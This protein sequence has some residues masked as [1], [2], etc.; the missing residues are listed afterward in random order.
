MNEETLPPSPNWYLSNVLA[1]RADGT[2]AYGSRNSIVI[3]KYLP[4]KS[5]SCT[6][7][8]SLIPNA[9]K[10]RITVIAFCTGRESSDSYWNCLA[11]A[12][13][14][15][16]I[17]VWNLETLSPLLAN[18]SHVVYNKLYYNSSK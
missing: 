3:A 2:I 11:S 17:R 15:S 9:H 12:G 10:E 13:D 5:A 4:G 16:V 18:T 14:D 1:C 8:I 6:P 7:G